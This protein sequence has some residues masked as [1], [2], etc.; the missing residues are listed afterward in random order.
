VHAET[1]TTDQTHGGCARARRMGSGRG[2]VAARGQRTAR[3]PVRDQL[4]ARAAQ[5]G[6]GLRLWQPDPV[7][8][9]LEVGEA[10]SISARGVLT[11]SLPMPRPFASR[12]RGWKHAP[13]QG[14]GAGSPGHLGELNGRSSTVKTAVGQRGAA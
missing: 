13:R 10:F 5:P 7:R 4:G 12:H 8:H 9:P 6:A 3:V 1:A 14:G 2:P 11:E